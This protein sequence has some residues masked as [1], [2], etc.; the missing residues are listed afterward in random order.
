[1]DDV[2]SPETA[3]KPR[4]LRPSEIAAKAKRAKKKAAKAKRPKVVK[5]KRKPGKIKVRP[6]A[7]IRTHRIDL[8]LPGSLK[9][10]LVARAKS[11]RRTITSIVS[12]LVEKMK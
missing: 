5:T 3:K 6:A 12:E 1:M 4:K 9:T 11:S 2:L 7:V 8:R 10:K